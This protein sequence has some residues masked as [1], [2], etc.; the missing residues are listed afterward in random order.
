MALT[1]AVDVNRYSDFCRGESHA[2]K[3]IQTAPRIAMPFV[4]LGELRAGFLRGTRGRQNENGLTTFLAS[5]RVF[6][7]FGDEATTHFYASLHNDLHRTGMP[8]PT[9]DLWIAALV[10]QHNLVLFTRDKHFDRI[11]R[12]PR[13]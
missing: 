3:I 8:I 9:N 4:V 10:L 12:L 6:V 5:P 1:I 13:V 11:A 2:C 7:L